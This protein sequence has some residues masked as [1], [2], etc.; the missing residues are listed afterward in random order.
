MKI[1]INVFWL[2]GPLYLK[3]YEDIIFHPIPIYAIHT[4]WAR[5]IIMVHYTIYFK[6]LALGDGAI[7]IY[8]FSFILKIKS[9]QTI[10]LIFKRNT[11]GIKEVSNIFE[12]FWL[13]ERVI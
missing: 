13:V 4:A 8:A 5:S 3:F 10:Y 9:K 2:Q 12:F 6:T 11:S 1:K 7:D